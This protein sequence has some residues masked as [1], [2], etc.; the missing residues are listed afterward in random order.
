MVK[1]TVELNKHAS[2]EDKRGDYKAMGQIQTMSL[3]RN[4]SF[5]T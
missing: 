1:A 2:H 4:L 5:D 3:R